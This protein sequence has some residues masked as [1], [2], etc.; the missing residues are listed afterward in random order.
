M[1]TP[2]PEH[3]DQEEANIL[4]IAAAILYRRYGPLTT[5]D[6][7]K[8]LRNRAGHIREQAAEAPRN[9]T[10]ERKLDDP[11]WPEEPGHGYHE[12]GDHP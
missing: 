5:G 8:L 4:E 3:D 7:I 11:W 12:A 9:A 6:A 1:S 10:L 2:T